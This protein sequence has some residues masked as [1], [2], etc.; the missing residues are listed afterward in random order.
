[1]AAIGND[2]EKLFFILLANQK[3]YW[4]KSVQGILALAKSYSPEIVNSSCARALAFGACEYQLVKRICK[5]GSYV[6]PLEIKR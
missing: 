3:H 2:A 4:H 6:L 1:M 5:S